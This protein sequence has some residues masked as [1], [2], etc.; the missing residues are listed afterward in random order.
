MNGITQ[1]IYIYILYLPYVLS[2]L[3]CNPLKLFAYNNGLFIHIDEQYS[4][5]VHAGLF[6]HLPIKVRL[7]FFSS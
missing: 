4:T 6:N 2:I 5:A 3:P 1:C 7:D